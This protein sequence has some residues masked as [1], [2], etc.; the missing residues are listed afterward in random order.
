MPYQ[1]LSNSAQKV[2]RAE[3]HI[4]EF[5]AGLKVFMD[6]LPYSLRVDTETE[7][8][9]PVVHVLKADPIPH[10][11]L[12]VLGDAI[13]NLRSALDHCAFALVRANHC[14]PTKR[15]EF[16]ILEGPIVSKKD[17]ATFM[18]KVEG[19]RKEVIDAIRGIRPYK[20]GDDLLW[21]LHRLDIIDKHHMLVAAFGSITAIDGFPPID[22]Q[23]KGD[24]WLG[25]PGVPSVLEPSQQFTPSI[26]GKKVNKESAF[27]AEVVFNEPDVAV[28]YPV[29]LALKQFHRHVLLT[30]GG[31]SWAL[32]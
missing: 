11:L 10:E 19:M 23:W 3:K 22:E 2:K 16:P 32:K 28:G 17:E 24:R 12:T 21:R 14:V 29:V 25:L 4:D 7:F 31:L 30:I 1:A 18:N 13:H 5:K 9:E 26:P 27:F 15:V 20:G 6:S 8:G